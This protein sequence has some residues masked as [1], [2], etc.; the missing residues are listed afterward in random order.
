MSVLKYLL[1]YL[2]N[3]NKS[4]VKSQ[5]LE[6]HPP[7]KEIIKH[8]LLECDSLKFSNLCI[9]E[10]MFNLFSEQHC[11]VLLIAMIIILLAEQK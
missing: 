11:L 10:D 4:T 7:H 9:L 1:G 2:S 5:K 3:Y 6:E 8:N